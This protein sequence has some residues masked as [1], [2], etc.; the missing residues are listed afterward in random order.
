MAT[1]VWL[2][3]GGHAS[4]IYALGALIMAIV[5]PGG[6]WSALATQGPAPNVFSDAES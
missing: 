6:R 4:A 3:D 2:R 5:S 1:F